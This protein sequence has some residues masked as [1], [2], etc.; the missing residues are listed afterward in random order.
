LPAR[1][2]GSLALTLA[3]GIIGGSSRGGDG[4]N[5][6]V[7]LLACG[8]ALL[9][10]MN[11]AP[12]ALGLDARLW[13][14]LAGLL[15]LWMALQLIPLPPMIWTSLPG[16]GI[17]V[18]EATAM[19]MAQPWRPI[20]LSPMNT[21]LALVGMTVP[22][23]L[24]LSWGRGDQRQLYAGRWLLLVLAAISLILGVLQISGGVGSGFYFFDNATRG[25]PAGLFSNRNHQAAALAM[26]F[27]LLGTAVL[28]ARIGAR[29][30]TVVIAGTC[31]AASIIL[32]FLLL[33]G[34]RAG[35]V[36]AGVSIT[37]TCLHI[38]TFRLPG[39]GTK[40]AGHRLVLA[41]IALVPVALAVLSFALGRAAAIERLTRLRLE[42]D[43][44]FSQLSTV[45]KIVRDHFP[46][47]AGYG[48]FAPVFRIYEPFGNLQFSYYN[49]AHND[50]V[51]LVFEGGAPAIVLALVA[52][53]S[54]ARNAWRVWGSPDRGLDMLYARTGSIM[55][56][57][58]IIASATD[59]PL[60]TPTILIFAMIALGWLWSGAAS[61][62]PAGLKSDDGRLL[63]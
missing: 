35:L 2:S 62:R 13:L 29:R 57:I 17:F 21:W 7:Q 37:L 51:E 12:A 53:A 8:L 24:L 52:L 20:S 48:T 23:A 32:P 40:S 49:H 61:A 55:I 14:R 63:R 39:R 26:V 19:S 3:I 44:R 27:P 5:L 34:S 15:T 18:P 16:R 43:Q 54:F 38:G 59:Y 31:F 60:R 56:V 22:I 47:G 4:L 10:V 41:A 58:L 36:L 6:F 33:T 42:D 25:Y 45:V 28:E 30:E 1:L 11:P 50:L 46:V 9:A